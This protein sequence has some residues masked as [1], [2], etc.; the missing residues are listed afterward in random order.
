[1]ENKECK[2]LEIKEWPN[3]DPKGNTKYTIKFDGGE[4]VFTSSKS[5]T[6]FVVGQTAKFT[7]ENLQ[8]SNGK[9]YVKIRRP[10]DP[11][12][13]A[14]AG[15]GF[16]PKTITKEQVAA[17]CC[18]YATDLFVDEKLKWEH[19]EPMVKS[20]TDEVWTQVETETT[21]DRKDACVYTMYNAVRA[22]GTGKLPLKDGKPMRLNEAYR[23]M[24]GA[25]M[26]CLKA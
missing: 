5:N 9:D 20:I 8:W 19:F 15:G 14:A 1:M 26:N 25:V 12:R 6:Y 18:S 2:I 11:A 17:K 21:Y 4:G 16:V 3:K 13:A 22:F 24:L 10:E 7:T 23:H